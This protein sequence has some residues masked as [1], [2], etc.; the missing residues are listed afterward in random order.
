VDLL[1]EGGLGRY[2][3]HSLMDR[4]GRLEHAGRIVLRMTQQYR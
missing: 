4:V 2:I 3:I 1:P